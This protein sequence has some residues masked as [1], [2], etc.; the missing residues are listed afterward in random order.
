M[1]PPG[2]NGQ[3]SYAS[4]LTGG[5]DGSLGDSLLGPIACE[6]VCRQRGKGG[7]CSQALRKRETWAVGLRTQRPQVSVGLAASGK[8]G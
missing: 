4:K 1:R 2:G 5:P 6:E 3:A 7:G 8:H